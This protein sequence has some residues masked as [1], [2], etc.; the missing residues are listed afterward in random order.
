MKVK[1]LWMQIAPQWWWGDHID[2][3]FYVYHKL[4]KLRNKKVLDIACNAGVL[5]TALHPN[6]EAYGIELE[7][8]KVVLARKQ[9]NA[10]ISEGSMFTY[11][12]NN[13]KAFYAEAVKK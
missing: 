10:K 6:N 4:S 13:H 12:L 9:T 1:K 2:V 11:Y 8:D 5:L 7:H 3:R